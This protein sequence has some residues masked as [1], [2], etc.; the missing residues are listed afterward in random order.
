[1]KI[2]FTF[3]NRKENTQ[4]E[5]NIEKSYKTKLCGKNNLFWQVPFVLVLQ[6]NLLNSDNI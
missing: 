4:H 5:G 3:H 2:Y 6:T 1:M